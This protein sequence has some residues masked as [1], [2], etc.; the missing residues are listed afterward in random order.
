MGFVQYKLQVMEQSLMRI[1]R[2]TFE[3][4]NWS[5]ANLYVKLMAHKRATRQEFSLHIFFFFFFFYIDL[6]FYVLA[7]VFLS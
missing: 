7:L 3:H 5:E 4:E 6:S 2:P 1:S